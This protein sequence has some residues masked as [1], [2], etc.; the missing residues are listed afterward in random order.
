MGHL[1]T[2]FD[3]SRVK[4]RDIDDIDI[5]KVTKDM[6]VCFYTGFIEEEGYGTK[7]YFTEHPQISNE[8]CRDD[9]I[10]LQSCCRYLICLVIDKLEV[11]GEI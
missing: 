9:G 4:N 6:F 10:A 8:L 2:H 11:G 5:N 3:V 1:G 7:K